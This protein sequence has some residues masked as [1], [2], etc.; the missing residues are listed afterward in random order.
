MAEELKLALASS[1]PLTFANG[2]RNDVWCLWEDDGSLRVEA[3]WANA[4]YDDI[5][6]LGPA[7][8]TFYRDVVLDAYRSSATTCC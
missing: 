3:L 8:E 6:S 4:E 1:T 5:D 7:F 2:T